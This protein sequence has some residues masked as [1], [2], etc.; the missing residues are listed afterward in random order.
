MRTP[1]AMAATA[2]TAGA[3]GADRPG[4]AAA[5]RSRRTAPRWAV[6]LLTLA[7][8]AVACGG[9]PAPKPQMA[10]RGPDPAAEAAA[11]A[12]DPNFIVLGE[13]PKWKPIRTLFQA[14]QG[15]EIDGVAN[16]TLANTSLFIEKPVIQQAGPDEP[17]V[18]TDEEGAPDLPDTCATKGDLDSY[19]LIILLTGIAEPKAVFIGPDANRCE[20]VRGDA[21]GNRGA[22]VAAITQYKVIIDVPGEEKTIE[23]SLVP[24]LKG[25]G[26]GDEDG[27]VP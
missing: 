1:L 2:A 19:K 13:N 16:V 24:P 9:E 5:A 6:L 15:R 8:L 4:A 21:I 12:E 17:V 3:A 14:Y 23:K 22:R 27:D 25:F 11:P 18:A 7:A 10:P 26:E 20:V